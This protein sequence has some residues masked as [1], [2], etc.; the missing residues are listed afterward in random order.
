MARIACL[1]L[2]IIF[3]LPM[4]V[5][6]QTTMPLYEGAIP[7]SKPGSNEEKSEVN[8]SNRL[9][10]SKVSRPTI[11]AYLPA[12]GKRNGAAVIICPGG[13]YSILAAG[14][15]G[16]DVAKKFNEMGV[17][18]F[19]LKY[20]LPNP[21]T[22]VQPEIGP[23]QDAQRAIQLVRE[24]ADKWGIHPGLIGIMGFSAGG[25]LAATAGTHFHET[26][27]Q[28]P[29][30]T[31]LRPDFMILVYPV[32]SFA[33]SVGHLGS[34]QQLLGRNPT[35]EQIRNFSNDVQVNAQTPPTFLVH[36]KDDPVKVENTLFFAAA[37]KK[38]GLPQRVYLYETGGHGYGM[39]NPKSDVKW[40]DLVNTWMVEFLG[41]NK[42]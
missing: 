3:T 36:A 23:L 24:G 9:I 10:I 7:N 8:S 27:I 15:E 13:G 19:V 11:T 26:H 5:S 22:M 31:S 14:H 42:N 12:K 4:T 38:I 16:A 33:D 39:D 35:Q 25:H 40:M 2:L 17:T 37:M 32:I 29:K 20:R 18:A 41:L 1:L 30:R 21:Q 34:R 28:N 6:A